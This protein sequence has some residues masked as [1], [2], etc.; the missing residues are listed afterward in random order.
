[1][2]LSTA[3]YFWGMKEIITEFYVALHPI[4]SGKIHEG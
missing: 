4:L 2:P 1:M 3:R